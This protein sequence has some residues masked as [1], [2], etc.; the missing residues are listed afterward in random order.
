MR[1]QRRSVRVFKNCLQVV[2]AHAFE[3]FAVI[4]LDF[5][6][7]LSTTVEESAATLEALLFV[8]QLLKRRED[9]EMV[10]IPTQY[11]RCRM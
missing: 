1:G 5:F 3:D 2:Q 11:G 8:M 7:E 6:N 10:F 4:Y 9:L